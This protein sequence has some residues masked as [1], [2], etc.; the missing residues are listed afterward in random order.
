[1][2]EA[3]WRDLNHMLF[4]SGHK[5]F[6]RQ[7]DLISAGNVIGAVQFSRYIRPYTETSCGPNDREPGF[8]RDWDLRWWIDFVGIPP[9]VLSFVV[10]VTENITVILYEFHHYLRGRRVTHGYVVTTIERR[11]LGAF[12]TGPTYKSEQVIDEATK[13]IVEKT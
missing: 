10:G 11:L 9:E 6:D 4:E 2:K 3:V 8:F 7:V 13:Y 1:M 5:T 12:V